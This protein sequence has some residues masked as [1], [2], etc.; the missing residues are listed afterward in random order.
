MR[1]LR[2]VGFSVVV[3]LLAL[4]CT[5]PIDGPPPASET[6]FDGD[7]RSIVIVRRTLGG[8]ALEELVFEP[9]T[10]PTDDLTTA[11]AWAC[12]TEI[13][14]SGFDSSFVN[15]CTNPVW[16]QDD[17]VNLTS[18]NWRKNSI[19]ASCE[20]G[21]LM[22]IATSVAPLYL[23]FDDANSN[24][25][26]DSTEDT[27]FS[28]IP[29]DSESLPEHLE[30]LK[31][32]L[33]VPPQLPEHQG[34]AAL[35]AFR[36]LQTS[37]A[38]T[39]LV[40]NPSVCTDTDLSVQPKLVEQLSA[41]LAESV[42]NLDEAARLV[43]E[44]LL[45]TAEARRS[46][47]LDFTQAN[48]LRW[49]APTD[50]RLDAARAGLVV[51][52]KFFG[53][54]GDFPVMTAVPEDPAD[55]RAY[56]LL[57]RVG[58]DPALSGSELRAAVQS[59]L[60]QEYP[61]PNGVAF[62]S[63]DDVL[64]AFGV[65]GPD[66]D[67][68]M[69]RHRQ[70][71]QV[72]GLASIPDPSVADGTR[73]LNLDRVAQE[74]PWAYHYALLEGSMDLGQNTVDGLTTGYARRGL[75]HALDFAHHVVHRARTRDL[76][77]AQDT[78]DATWAW[79]DAQVQDRAR[80]CHVG[81]RLS[82]WRF[83]VTFHDA[84]TVSGADS[85]AERYRVFLGEAGLECAL[86]GRIGQA[87]CDPDEWEVPRTA[88]VQAS[89]S[90]N[91][92]GSQTAR[93]EL[94]SP[95]SLVRERIYFTWDRDP[96][97]GSRELL[98]GL[99]VTVPPSEEP[100]LLRPSGDP[101]P[102]PRHRDPI[103]GVED[104]REDE[105][106]LTS[107]PPR[108]DGTGRGG[109]EGVPPMDDI[110]CHFIPLGPALER[111]LEVLRADPFD[112]SESRQ[113]CAGV[114]SNV[115]VK[116]EDELT[117][118]FNGR[119]GIESSVAA[120]LRTAR[121]SADEA[122]RLGDALFNAKLSFDEY[123]SSE[124]LREIS[125]DQR[126]TEVASRL[127]NL[128]GGYIDPVRLMDAACDDEE[129]E[130]DLA[131]FLSQALSSSYAES[132]LDLREETA[133]DLW[134]LRACL[135]LGATA[136]DWVAVGEKDLCA[137]Q[138]DGFP[139]CTC[140]Q[141]E[142]APCPVVVNGPASDGACTTA[143][144]L[145]EVVGGWGSCSAGTGVETEC[146]GG[147]TTLGDLYAPHPITRHLNLGSMSLDTDPSTCD[148]LLDI[149]ATSTNYDGVR[150]AL[151]CSAHGFANA[152][153]GLYM[154]D[155]PRDV[156][157][158]LEAGVATGVF[159]SHRGS[160]GSQVAGVAGELQ[161]VAQLSEL[162][163][164][165][166]LHADL[167]VAGLELQ[168][169]S[170]EV[171][172]ELDVLN[173]NEQLAVH[174]AECIAAFAVAVA[175]AVGI[176]TLFHPGDPLGKSIEAAA[177]CMIGT[178]KVGFATERL[179]LQNALTSV[180]SGQAI[181]T[182]IQQL[183]ARLDTIEGHLFAI[184]QTFTRLNQYMAQLD[185]VRTEAR[186]L[187]N[188]L[189]L[190][191]MQRTQPD[192]VVNRAYAYRID[193][194]Q[195]QYDEAL[196]RAK[197]DSLL[198]LRAIEQRIGMR[199]AFMNQDM[200][201]GLPAPQTWVHRICATSGLDY[202]R[203]HDEEN[204]IPDGYDPADGH[205]GEVVSLLED[206]LEAYR[207]DFPF[208]DHED[209]LVLSL[210]EDI[211]GLVDWCE[212][213]QP[214]LLLGTGQLTTGWMVGCS[215]ASCGAVESSGAA[216]FSFPGSVSA[217]SVEAVTLTTLPNAMGAMGSG[218][219][220]IEQE[221]SVPAGDYVLSWYGPDANPLSPNI[222]NLTAGSGVV[223]TFEN[224]PPSTD[225]IWGR[226]VLTFTLPAAADLRVGFEIT[227]PGAALLAP[228]LEAGSIAS[229]MFF[230]TDDDLTAPLV[231]A[232]D[233][234]GGNVIGAMSQGVEYYCPDG[235]GLDCVNTGAIDPEALP[236]RRYLA[237]SFPL[238][239][240]LI[241]S[242]AMLARSGFALGNFNYRHQRI[243]VWV[244]GGPEVTYCPPSEPGVSSSCNAD[245][246]FNWSLFHTGPFSVRN[247]LND[248]FDA[249]VYPGRIRQARGGI[250]S[251]GVRDPFFQTDG[252]VRPV[253]DDLMVDFNGRPFEGNVELRIYD[254]D[255]LNLEAIRDIQLVVDYSYWARS[256]F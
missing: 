66:L 104:P 39:G 212:E 171:Q 164:Q 208:Q 254:D 118:M 167:E 143:F 158:D 149:S 13:R 58:V 159:P 75:A 192:A 120:S 150:D 107:D 251:G 114:P 57:R 193:R 232:T 4:A 138:P 26:L 52:G 146:D 59:A 16:L 145:D 228:Q 222:E 72:L 195:Y 185:S 41:T 121:A 73:F 95:A 105:R 110:S 153:D 235:T 247:H 33:I 217:V 38:W 226:C 243:G 174:G 50:S 30:G 154:A 129:A 124:A 130:C 181:R 77:A 56:A 188:Q 173:Y 131:A 246:H 47:E 2:G 203:L 37:V 22:S 199:L 175:E 177:T 215:E 223:P 127:T 100:Q 86:T 176:K 169:A 135:G 32:P 84:P 109:D 139:V 200:A 88:T 156:I 240:D 155:L 79:L 45:T 63:P 44:R 196:R 182:T 147:V 249:P 31:N 82:D 132:V 187:I 20:A 117:E 220:A 35:L 3:C 21:H 27:Y 17:T 92:H 112:P 211:L 15:G 116:L 9:G 48:V 46:E 106:H 12:E 93:V 76:G 198:S 18:D 126:M 137:Y 91:D 207:H 233:G 125:I 11:L 201:F 157:D 70:E 213:D 78:V 255:R 90:F 229:P 219:P 238:D 113:S 170:Y 1:F 68:A 184:R 141:S 123:K 165:E 237:V 151:R 85:G 24:D 97:G 102:D 99:T 101:D 236:Q 136:V 202:D 225:G 179:T 204:A 28:P 148:S 103:F 55:E 242:G 190:L 42:M 191:E 214:N 111:T 128:C 43:Q 144:G 98:L 10:E 142:C 189:G 65:S 53:H 115:R 60:N 194:L 252:T 23:Y 96:L 227:G 61:S 205:I 162:V 83:H 186:A 54:Q 80:V 256:N 94:T 244:D 206:F 29:P 163:A 36:E 34:T 81:D 69:L 234:D 160:Y 245:S 168:L 40:L 183:V 108:D 71:L 51:P 178:I 6:T 74:T 122:E 166:L 133:S 140:L 119:D 7:G 25:H 134:G 87:V 210:R 161:A 224:C 197:R 239:L 49:R 5:S 209:T 62:A 230:A 8:S 14:E 241:E 216:P 67:R 152:V 19:R 89:G 231:C 172:E 248:S 64:V 218:T 253:I 180:A 250:S 221:V